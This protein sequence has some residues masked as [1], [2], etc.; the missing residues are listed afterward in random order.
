VAGDNWPRFDPNDR[1]AALRDAAQRIIPNRKRMTREDAENIV[2]EEFARRGLPTSSEDVAHQART[3]HRGPF[4]PFLHP[5]QARREGWRTVWP[6]SSEH[7]EQD[8]WDC[9]PPVDAA[10]NAEAWRLAGSGVGPL[11]FD[12]EPAECKRISKTEYFCV[13]EVPGSD[14]HP[15]YRVEVSI[16]YAVGSQPRVTDSQ[17][18]HR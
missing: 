1:F 17:F 13:A 2:R 9:P 14:A 16:T 5:R 3:F 7:D 8:P 10:A 12:L 11:S 4:W 6:W 18:R 15:A